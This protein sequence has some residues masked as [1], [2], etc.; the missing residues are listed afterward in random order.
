M[1]IDLVTYTM[2]AYQ[3]YTLPT[4]ETLDYLQQVFE[5]CP[6][7]IDWDAC[8]VEINL[9]TDHRVLDSLDLNAEYTCLPICHNS[10]SS[11]QSLVWQYDALTE[12]TNLY[13][14][15]SSEQLLQAAYDS[16]AKY[17]S[18]YH[19]QP[20]LYMIIKYDYKFYRIYNNFVNSISDYFYQYQEPLYFKGKF[21]RSI[22]A[23]IPNDI[24][25]YQSYGLK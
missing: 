15:L 6:F 21:V 20:L 10:D 23:T 4:Q 8:A 24:D 17:Q 11:N 13:L 12:M 22:D 16:R 19:T 18:L 1:V 5:N 14:P 2:I 9:T 7:E 3:L 25:F